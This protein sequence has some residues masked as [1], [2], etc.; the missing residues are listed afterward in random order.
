MKRSS[1][2]N[3]SVCFS[4]NSTLNKFIYAM[5]RLYKTELILEAI[6]INLM[7]HNTL[8]K[9]I[10]AG[11]AIAI[12]ATNAPA[13]AKSD[14]IKNYKQLDTLALSVNAVTA[15][16]GVVI[17]WAIEPLANGDLLIS[18][19]SGTL[20][21]LPKNTTTLTK[22]SGLPDIDANGQ[23][24]LLDLS[25][26]TDSKQNQWLYFSYSSSEGK[27]SG[28]NTALNARQAK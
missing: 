14:Y 9:L 16:E 6:M 22:V 13:H 2:K 25:L 15:A 21:L 24:G 20:F 27:G 18:E 10:S 3:R 4:F 5:L 17:P 8:P 11:L 28:S 23:G 19:R 26:H 1:Y 7:S 12:F